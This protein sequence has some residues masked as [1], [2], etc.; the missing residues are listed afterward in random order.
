MATVARILERLR[1]DGPLAVVRRIAAR[2]TRRLYGR[3]SHVWYGL[4]LDGE[5]PHP[6]L[7]EGI[8]LRPGTVDDV[9]ALAGIMNQPHRDD[10][11]AQLANDT[12]ELYVAC[13]GDWVVFACWIFKERAPVE[14][15]RGGWLELPGDTVCLEDSGVSPDFR[16]RGVAGATWATVADGLAER[17]Y[18]RMITKV[19]EDNVPSRKAVSKA[20]FMESAVM[21]TSRVAFV[22][23]VGV[24]SL[25]APWAEPLFGGLAR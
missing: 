11:T 19:A 23:R 21:R 18:S 9:P 8:R 25:G 13:E 10:A 20:G 15:A 5:R 2:V 17:G 22:T 24:T 1:S 6:V 3:E 14:A 12:A 4:A 16:G 7:P